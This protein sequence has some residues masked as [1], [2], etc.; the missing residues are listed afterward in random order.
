MKMVKLDAEHLFAD[1]PKEKE[2]YIKV[3]E[4]CN[5]RGRNTFC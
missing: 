1:R 3:Y 4:E 2:Y 5:K